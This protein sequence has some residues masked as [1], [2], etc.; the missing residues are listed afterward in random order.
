MS[1][2]LTTAIQQMAGTYQTDK[3]H[4]ILGTVTAVNEDE[5]TCDVESVNGDAT[6]TFTG[7]QLMAGVNDGMLLIPA[8]DS[9]VQITYSNNTVPYVTLYSQLDKII[10][11]ADSYGIEISSGG[12]VLNNGEYGGL[13]K[14]E[15]VVSKLNNLENDINTLKQVFSAWSPVSNDGGAALKTAAATWYA[16]QLTQ[17]VKGDLENTTV[18]HGSEL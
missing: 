11:I 15:D 12:V 10:Y 2:E 8:I 7:V 4:T 6:V 14:V 18:T 17:T 5:R 3:V 1:R 16:Q 9:Q 13:V